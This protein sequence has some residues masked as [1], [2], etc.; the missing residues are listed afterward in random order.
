[1]QHHRRRTTGSRRCPPASAA[2][3]LLEPHLAIVKLGMPDNSSWFDKHFRMS[4]KT[5]DFC[6][7]PE[8]DHCL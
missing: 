7:F 5:P 3:P 2:L 8:R 4:Q 1:M 6:D